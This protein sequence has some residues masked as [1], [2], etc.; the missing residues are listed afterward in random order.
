MKRKFRGTPLQLTG[1]GLRKATTFDVSIYSTAPNGLALL[2][3][4]DAALP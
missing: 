1:L 3:S 2:W 4:L